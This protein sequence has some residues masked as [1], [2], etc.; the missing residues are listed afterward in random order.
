MYCAILALQLARIRAL[1]YADLSLFDHHHFLLFVHVSVLGNLYRYLALS[2]LSS[3]LAPYPES[4]ALA[5]FWD[6]FQFY[7]FTA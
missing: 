2:Y 7:R 4:M 5:S 6:C 3:A 1:I